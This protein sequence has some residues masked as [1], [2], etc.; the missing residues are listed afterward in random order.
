MIMMLMTIPSS[1]FYS[2]DLDISYKWLIT[3]KVLVPAFG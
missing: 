3:S 1:I 2:K